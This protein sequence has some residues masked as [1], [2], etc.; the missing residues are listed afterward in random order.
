MRISP[1][2]VIEQAKHLGLDTL[3]Y[4]TVPKKSCFFLYVVKITY[5][6]NL[7]ILPEQLFPSPVR[8]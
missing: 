2:A 7:Y 1:G 5:V 4:L 8:K 3:Y 6:D